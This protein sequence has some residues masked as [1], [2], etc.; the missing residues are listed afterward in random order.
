VDPCGILLG[1]RFTEGRFDWSWFLRRKTGGAV[2]RAFPRAGWRRCRTGGFPGIRL[3]VLSVLLPEAR[4]RVAMWIVDPNASRPP[5]TANGERGDRSFWRPS[6]QGFVLHLSS[7]WSLLSLPGGHVA[8][9]FL[10]VSRGVAWSEAIWRSER[11]VGCA[12]VFS[13]SLAVG[14]RTRSWEGSDPRISWRCMPRRG[15]L[16][17][18]E[19]DGWGGV[20]P[21]WRPFHHGHGFSNARSTRFSGFSVESP[22]LGSNGSARTKPGRSVMRDAP[23]RT[24]QSRRRNRRECRGPKPAASRTSPKAGASRSRQ[25]LRVDRRGGFRCCGPPTVSSFDSVGARPTS[26]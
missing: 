4:G 17:R 5:D 3:A 14:T 8:S 10:R 26:L 20:P 16:R 21:F 23:L 18:L 25:G 7:M 19:S 22:G 12:V 9:F 13:R 24:G 11:A 2:R 6:H 15:F 1:G